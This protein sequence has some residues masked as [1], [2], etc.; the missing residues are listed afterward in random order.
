[1]AEISNI[2]VTN[3]VTETVEEGVEVLAFG[4]INHAASFE[5]LGGVT[6]VYSE[7]TTDEKRVV[8]TFVALMRA[9]VLA[10]D[11]S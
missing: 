11:E 4:F 2:E 8:D 1:M 5:M 10:S 7:L 6:I 3:H 9:K